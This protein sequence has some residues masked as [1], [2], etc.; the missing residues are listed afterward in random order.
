MPA[1]F[2]SAISVDFGYSKLLYYAGFRNRVP[3][4]E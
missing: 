4:K 1:E 2:V 3:V